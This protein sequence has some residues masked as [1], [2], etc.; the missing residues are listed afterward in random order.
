MMMS[1]TDSGAWWIGCKALILEERK[2]STNRRVAEVAT[3]ITRKPIHRL[4]ALSSSRGRGH[5]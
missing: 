1:C 4:G 2:K 3:R 5:S